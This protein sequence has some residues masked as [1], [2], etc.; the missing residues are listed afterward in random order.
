MDSQV[1]LFGFLF[2]PERGS[3]DSSSASPLTDEAKILCACGCKTYFKK[4]DSRN[5]IRFFIHGH[6]RKGKFHPNSQNSLFIKGHV[7]TQEMRN[8]I[9]SS[10]KGKIVSLETR[11]NLSKSLLGKPRKKEYVDKYLIGKNNPSW[12]GGVTPLQKT[13]RTSEKYLKWRT[14]IFNRDRFQ[15]QYCYSI[16]NRL[17][18]HHIKPYSTIIQKNNIKTLQNAYYC[19]ELWSIDNGITLCKPCHKYEHKNILLSTTKR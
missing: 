5:R 1:T 6:N 17:N 3:T 19:S 12:K 2:Q 9:S 18:V 4:Y 13:I 15:C 8:K 10:N 14:T 16:G 7:P 11:K